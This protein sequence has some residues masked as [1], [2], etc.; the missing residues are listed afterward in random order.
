LKLSDKE[1]QEIKDV[2]T[3][4]QFA[5]V[6]QKIEAKRSPGMIL[7]GIAFFFLIFFR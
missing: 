7:G 2:K 6:R 4:E 3:Q 5:E 1:T